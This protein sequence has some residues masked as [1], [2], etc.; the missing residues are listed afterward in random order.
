MAL[1]S[2]PECEKEVSDQAAKC[3]HCG[4]KLR[5]GTFAKSV[6]GATVVL[7]L[8][9]AYGASIPEHEAKANAARRVCEKELIPRGAATQSECDRQ[10]SRMLSEGERR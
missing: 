8:F 4:A 6:I 1:V 3:P 2:C 5:M 7:G 9:L 10:Y